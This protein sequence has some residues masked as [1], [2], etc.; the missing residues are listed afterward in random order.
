G[1]AGKDSV[2]RRR[3]RL[4]RSQRVEMAAAGR[5]HPQLQPARAAGEDSWAEVQRNGEQTIADGGG[6]LCERT[7]NEVPVGRCVEDREDEIV[8]AGGG[9]AAGI[10]PA[11][12]GERGALAP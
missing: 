2:R 7:G 4:A 9:A 5:S 8:E 1:G 3:Q 10:D 6:R 12:I 11:L